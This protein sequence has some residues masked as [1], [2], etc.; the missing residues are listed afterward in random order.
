MDQP[1]AL[2]RPVVRSLIERI[3]AR[4]APE[5]PGL[6]MD[7]PGAIANQT[8]TS[9]QQIARRY[10]ELADCTPDEEAR[11]NFAGI[12]AEYEERAERI[13]SGWAL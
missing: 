6:P 9:F 12:A 10:R 11:V 13:S 3:F 4:P 7:L 8:A 5:A 2:E 1:L